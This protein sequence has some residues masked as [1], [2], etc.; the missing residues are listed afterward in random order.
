MDVS[1]LPGHIRGAATEN[2]RSPKLFV[3]LWGEKRISWDEE[4]VSRTRYQHWDEERV[5]RK[6]YPHCETGFQI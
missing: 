5:S 6:R 4:R 3:R 1:V 2:A